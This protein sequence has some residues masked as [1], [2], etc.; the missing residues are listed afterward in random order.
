VTVNEYVPGAAVPALT[1]RVDEP[2]AVTE[3]GLSDAD[4]PAGTP[5][6]LNAT[7]SAEPVMTAVLTVDAPEDPCNT[8][9]EVGVALME[10]SL[11]AGAVT[12]S[13]NEVA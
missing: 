11:A 3:A 8:E 12:V 2:P 4:A 13:D 6:T 10:K 1:E 7:D 5:D 9:S